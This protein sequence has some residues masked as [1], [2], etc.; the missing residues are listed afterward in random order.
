MFQRQKR[1]AAHQEIGGGDQQR[2]RE[3]E[4]GVEGGRQH[5]SLR[6]KAGHFRQHAHT[7]SSVLTM[8]AA[9]PSQT[10]SSGQTCSR[11][12]YWGRVFGNRHVAAVRAFVQISLLELRLAKNW[13]I[14]WQSNPGFTWH[15]KISRNQ[16]L[17]Q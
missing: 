16:K 1:Q 13:R 6:E 4:R 8:D 10:Q 15:Q 2:H 11:E 3:K 7:N 5:L 12:P 17:T 14:L 9:R